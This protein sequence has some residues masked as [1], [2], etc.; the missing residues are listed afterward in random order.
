MTETERM[1]KLHHRAATGNSLTAENETALKNW[2][3]TLD[4]QEAV[5]N[6]QNRPI[7]IASLR[8]NLEKTTAQIAIVSRDVGA[9]LKQNEK[10]RRENSVLRRRLEAGLTEQAA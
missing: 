5:I 8:E 9:L 7:E 6:R 4:R 10:L 3:E 2:Y 1:Q